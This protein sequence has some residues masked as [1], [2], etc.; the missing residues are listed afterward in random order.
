MTYWG[1]Y[2]FYS[3]HFVGTSGDY[4]KVSLHCNS[5][6]LQN[7]NSLK[8]FQRKWNSD[9][10]SDL[11]LDPST[12]TLKIILCD[13]VLHA[14]V[15]VC[16]FLCFFASLLGLSS[17][18]LFTFPL[19]QLRRKTLSRWAAW[20]HLQPVQLPS[21]LLCASVLFGCQRCNQIIPLRGQK[22]CKP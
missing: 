11:F 21:R 2:S 19:L 3:Q 10:V 16:L 15:R 12:K 22:Y 4:P 17:A 18:N 6:K 5:T 8:S 1:K 9:T 13:Q 7:P 20:A 14:N